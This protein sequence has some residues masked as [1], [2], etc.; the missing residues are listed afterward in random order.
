MLIFVLG[1]LASGPA[2][3]PAGFAEQPP[4]KFIPVVTLAGSIN[5]AVAEFVVRQ[6]AKAEKENAP[7][8]VIQLDTPGGLDTSMRTIVQGLLNAQIP[9]VVFVSPSGARAASA[10]VLIVL[11][12]DVAAMAPGTNIGAASPVNIGGKDI[13]KTMARKV[14]NDMVAYARSIAAQR[15]RNADWAASAVSKSESVPAEKALELKVIDLLAKDLPDLLQKIDGLQVNTGKLPKVLRTKGTPITYVQ[16]GFRDRV[17]RTISDPNIAYLL[18][19][20][21]TMG[22]F[23]E[24]INPGNIFPG[25]I[26]GISLILAFFALQ[27][28]PVNYA[29]LLLILLA[30]IFFIA[31]VKVVSHGLLS[32]G[33]VI[34]L[35]LGSLFLFRT[36]DAHL[37][38]ALGVLVPVVII[39]SGFFLAVASLAIRAYQRKPQTGEQGI[40]GEVGRV[41]QPIRPEA[42]GKV[43]VHGEI[44]NARS[45]EILETGEIVEV[46]GIDHL[47]LTVK[48]KAL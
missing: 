37:G 35:T 24:L 38:V 3:D 18:M 27:T 4:G 22:I 20:L 15:Q 25:V 46:V 36:D 13:E 43:F 41:R 29:G 11:A 2:W 16:E 47:L 44:W 6:I 33:G 23:F 9:V 8:L 19:M 12:A 39:V 10:G 5:P 48:K 7:A 28:L 17:L 34:S 31:E 40:L 21:G 30:I 42:P 32:I 26:G 45:L 1:L 14:E